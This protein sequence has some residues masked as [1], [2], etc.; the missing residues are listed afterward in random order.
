M[1]DTPASRRAWPLSLARLTLQD[2]RNYPTLRLDLEPGA[3]VL[4]GPNGAGKT[5]LLEALSLLTPGRGLRRARLR[6]LDRTGGAAWAVAATVRTTDGAREVGTGRIE[7]SETERRAVRID[8]EPARGTSALAAIA[9]CIWLTPAMDRLL[10]DSAAP[11]RRFLDRLVFTQEPEHAVRVAGY[12]HALRERAR[13]LRTRQDDGEWL[14]ALEARAAK[15]GVAIGTARRRLVAGLN[16]AVGVTSSD[17]PRPGLLVRGRIETWLETETEAAV[18]GRMIE[19]LAQSRS[20]DA[21]TGGAGLGPHRSDLAV[22]DI[23]LDQPAAR[24]STGRQKALLIAIVLAKTRLH[25]QS[26]AALP[27]LLLDEVIAH[28]DALRRD[29]LFAEIEALGAQAWLTGTDADL[30]RPLARSAQFFHVRD[31]TVHAT[32]QA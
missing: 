11:R 15:L 30:F 31:A 2:F 4:T 20:R 12:E 14:R 9:S 8:G 18:E 22:Q 29:A 3:V 5:N 16:G 21:E 25:G 1:T 32:S 23:E 19:G 13:L 6:D 26:G 27:L 28:L 24:S 10:A 7:A 17:F